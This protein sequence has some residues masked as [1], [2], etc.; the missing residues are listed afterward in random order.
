MTIYKSLEVITPLFI[1]V[2]IYPMDLVEECSHWGIIM[3]FM[4]YY[5][6]VLP[7]S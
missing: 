7:T 4:L 5:L 6:L 3:F 2:L 1:I